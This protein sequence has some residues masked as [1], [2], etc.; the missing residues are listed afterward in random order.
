MK[1]GIH[2]GKIGIRSGY[3]F[4][5]SMARPRPKSGQ[6]PPPPGSHSIW[7]ALKQL[8]NN[9][10]DGLWDFYQKCHFE[11]SGFSFCTNLNFIGL[12]L[13]EIVADLQ[14]S[15]VKINLKSREKG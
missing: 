5:T 8:R 14:G 6:V 2:F 15:C 13:L 9:R 7:F 3:V 11:A 1:S 10:N 12:Y 4:E